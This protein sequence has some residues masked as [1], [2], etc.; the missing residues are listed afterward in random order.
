MHTCPQC[1][2]DL[3]EKTAFCPHCGKS[4]AE[5]RAAADVVSAQAPD[6]PKPGAETGSIP[7]QQAPGDAGQGGEAPSSR[8]QADD[9]QQPVEAF[10]AEAADQAPSVEDKKARFCYSCGSRLPERGKFCAFC[11]APA[12]DL[13]NRE[14][15]IPI[16][17]PYFPYE[18]EQSAPA[19]P[20]KRKKTG[21][22]V[23]VCAIVALVGISA[24]LLVTSQTGPKI[25]AG[26]QPVLYVQGDDTLKYKFSSMEKAEIISGAF[27]TQAEDAFTLKYDTQVT[28]PDGRYLLYLNDF[29]NRGYTETGKG[30]LF[31]RD[32]TKR[33][34]SGNPTDKGIKIASDVTTQFGFGTALD[35]VF[36]VNTRGELYVWDFDSSHRL[37]SDVAGLLDWNDKKLLYYKGD[38]VDRYTSYVTNRDFYLVSLDPGDKQGRLKIDSDIN[39]LWDWTEDFGKF[40]YTKTSRSAKEGSVLFDVVWYDTQTNTKETLISDIDDVVDANAQ[41]GELLYLLTRSTSLRLSDVLED[42]ML[43]GDAKIV[44]PKLSDYPLLEKYYEDYSWLYSTDEEFSYYDLYDEMDQYEKAEKEYMGKEQRDKL[45]EKLNGDLSQHSNFELSFYD[46]YQLKG[47][48]REKKDT[49]VYCANT[50]S[51]DIHGDVREGYASYLKLDMS[52]IKKKKISE[53]DN[54]YMMYTFDTE[55]YLEETL[56]KDLY[57][58]FLDG[59]PTRL[60]GQSSKELANGYSVVLTAAGDGLYFMTT[61]ESTSS[62]SYSGSSKLYYVPITDKALGKPALV[63]DNVSSFS[64]ANTYKGKYYYVTGG[65]EKGDL[66]TVQG[67]ERDRISYDVSTDA[68]VDCVDENT[69]CFY[70]NY[71]YS[72]MMGELYILGDE[73]TKV[74]DDVYDYFYR[75][76]DQ[77]YLLRNYRAGKGDLYLYNGTGLELVDYDVTMVMDSYY[78]DPE[79]NPAI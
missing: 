65:G 29:R 69:L 21:V 12:A 3:Q 15:I 20:S 72:S 44:E 31:L 58:T 70:E 61:E 8:M 9:A 41:T 32:L 16:S 30:D 13:T 64:Y 24:V 7:E 50:Y 34:G 54:S 27:D 22:I 67:S 60:A 62:Y 5:Q 78:F 40:V 68:Y 47:K 18:P 59:S 26:E 28:S 52:V 56:V 49:N 57:F 75:G 19:Q 33:I 39:D 74:A 42:D 23:A 17:E 10:P 46:L 14:S 53:L 11:G 36:Y 55:S 71:N 35:R 48:V 76:K 45:R 2:R 38:K 4:L 73:K 63:D 37:D 77:I 79:G 66:Y 43:E 51:G 1:G 6:A 25:A